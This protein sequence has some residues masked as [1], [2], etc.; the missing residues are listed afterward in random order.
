V[1]KRTQLHNL[2]ALLELLFEERLIDFKFTI[3]Q[4]ENVTCRVI[5]ST[6]TTLVD[7]PLIVLDMP[8]RL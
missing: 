3:A 4:H 8:F 5:Y 6:H 1:T 2:V 7:L